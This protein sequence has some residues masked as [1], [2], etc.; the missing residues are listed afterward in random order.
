M[1]PAEFFKI[2]L[3]PMNK[4]AS[5]V[6]SKGIDFNPQKIISQRI[7]FE[8][9]QIQGKFPGPKKHDLTGS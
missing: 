7:W 4:I 1:N 9:P 5:F 6:K 2:D 3:W 8:K